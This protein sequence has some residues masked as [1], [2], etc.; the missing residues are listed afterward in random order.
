MVFFLVSSLFLFRFH[1]LKNNT[2]FVVVFIHVQ[3][4]Q[5]CEMCTWWWWY[6]CICVGVQPVVLKMLFLPYL[7][8]ESNCIVMTFIFYDTGGDKI[9]M[10]NMNPI[11]WNLLDL[12]TPKWTEFLF[13]QN[14]RAYLQKSILLCFNSKTKVNKWKRKR[15][16]KQNKTHHIGINRVIPY[17][18]LAK[19]YLQCW[20]LFL[21]DKIKTKQKINVRMDTNDSCWPY[22]S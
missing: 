15:K 18:L 13:Y 10:L 19:K 16:K 12:R 21:R 8:K 5:I 22:D 9:V 17:D 4:S 6:W 20:I 7:F 3:E 1:N 2:D 11:Y 14:D